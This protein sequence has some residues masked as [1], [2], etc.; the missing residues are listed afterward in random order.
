MDKAFS[1]TDGELARCIK[2]RMVHE[3]QN[4]PRNDQAKAIVREYMRELTAEIINEDF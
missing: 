4:F 3:L 1:N 2:S